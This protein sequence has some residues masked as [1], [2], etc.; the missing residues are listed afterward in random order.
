MA[1]TLQMGICRLPPHGVLT[2]CYSSQ[3]LSPGT[4]VHISSQSTPFQRSLQSTFK[5]CTVQAE[6]GIDAILT[7]LQVKQPPLD[8]VQLPPLGLGN[9]GSGSERFR[10]FVHEASQISEKIGDGA[11]KTCG[12]NIEQHPAVLRASVRSFLNICRTDRHSIW[13]SLL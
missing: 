5:V 11:V 1:E 2:P 6:E 13:N 7:G 4:P 8:N 12:R 10:T 9:F 3:R